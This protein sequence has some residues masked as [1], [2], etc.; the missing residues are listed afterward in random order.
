MI[1]AHD[2]PLLSATLVFD[3][4]QLL[5]YTEK[6]GA[7]EWHAPVQ[8]LLFVEFD[9]IATLCHFLHL[10]YAAIRLS[11]PIFSPVMAF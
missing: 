5:D 9:Y 11:A 10:Y 1:F 2:T 3:A 7:A 4:T 8:R 6:R